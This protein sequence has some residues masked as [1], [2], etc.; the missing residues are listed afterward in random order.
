MRPITFSLTYPAASANAIATAQQP[1]AAGNLT[2]TASPYKLSAPA[3]ITITSVS[4]ESAKTFT[5]TGADPSGNVQTEAIAGGNAAKVTTT[6]AFSVVTSIAVSAG[7]TGNVTVGFAQA[8]YSKPVPVDT[9]RAA[10]NIGVNVTISGTVSCTVQHTFDDVLGSTT[11]PTWYNHLELTDLTVSTANS[12]DIPITA[13][14]L[15]VAS[16]GGTS[17]VNIVQAGMPGE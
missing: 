13:I 9:Y 1:L 2:L 10:F 17:T 11:T 15:K 3:Y 12:Y 14:R 16:G 8:G 7:T 5:V 4:D 6:N